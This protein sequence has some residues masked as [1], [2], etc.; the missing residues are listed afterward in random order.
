MKLFDVY[1][2]YDI[3][4]VR[5][6]DV[7]VWDSDGTRYL[8]SYGGHAVISIGH[9]HPHFTARVGA[10]LERL[11]F[12]SNA[13]PNSLQDEYAEALAGVSGYPEYQLFLCNTGAEANENALKLASFHT[14]R[15]AV[16]AFRGAFHGRTSG[17]IAATDNPGI[18]A[19]F[20]D[21]HEVIFVPLND[22]DATRAAFAVHRFAAVI[23]EGIQGVAGIREADAAFLTELRMLCDNHGAVLILDEVQSGCARCGSFFAHQQA[24]VRADIVTMAKG[25]GNGFPV[26]GLLIAPFITPRHGL[27][28][29]TFGGGQLASAAALA[30]VEVIA[31]QQL[32]ANAS[33]VGDWLRVKLQTIPGITEVRGRGLM[34]G[35][36][37]TV[38]A[39]QLRERLLRVHHV[40]TGGA[41]PNTVR[42]LP[43]LT[44]KMEQAAE[45][46]AA[47]E[48]S[49][50]EIGEPETAQVQGS[51][52]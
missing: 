4:L 30:V 16:L 24:E 2:R 25:M 31:R 46:A 17:A 22:I 15:R 14:G 19:P 44:L 11:P 43:P 47:I 8:D 50:A 13:F 49:L 32:Q 26:A 10:Q 9:A 37:A 20:N 1:P 33:A 34:L 6:E 38:P 36:D 5:G 27:L 39:K 40:V 23:V 42:L 48:I 51:T 45:L 29:T 7:W 21:G 28:G 18:R 12:Y 52:T 41:G 3:E 35:F